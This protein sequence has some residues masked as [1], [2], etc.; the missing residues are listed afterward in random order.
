MSALCASVS[1]FFFCRFRFRK[2]RKSRL[3]W[4]FF[5]AKSYFVNL[6]LFC[7]S[8]NTVK[9]WRSWKN[10]SWLPFPSVSSNDMIANT[11]PTIKLAV[12]CRKI[13][14]LLRSFFFPAVSLRRQTIQTKS[15]A[16]VVLFFHNRPRVRATYFTTSDTGR[17]VNSWIWKE[18]NTC[19]RDSIFKFP[20]PSS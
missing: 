13:L 12:C 16:F 14:R 1:C 2:Y 17:E 11:S 4:V 18:R 15:I 19:K 8:L 10:G 3:R 7:A 9:T 6:I 5:C 20:F